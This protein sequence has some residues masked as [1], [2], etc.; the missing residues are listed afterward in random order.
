MAIR[1]IYLPKDPSQRETD[2]EIG[3]CYEVFCYFAFRF[4]QDGN[5]VILCFATKSKAA[6]LLGEPKGCFL[7][8]FVPQCRCKPIKAI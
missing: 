5:A 4:G 2:K 3:P 8:T 1:N 7:A 6:T